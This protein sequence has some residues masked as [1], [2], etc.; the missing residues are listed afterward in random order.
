MTYLAIILCAA[1]LAS[2]TGL[3][4][5]VYEEMKKHQDEV[6]SG[7]APAGRCKNCNCEK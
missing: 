2:L 4:I 5:F 1:W 3:V 7:K 6:S